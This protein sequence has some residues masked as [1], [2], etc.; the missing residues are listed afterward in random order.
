MIPAIYMDISNDGQSCNPTQ[1]QNMSIDSYVAYH[2]LLQSIFPYLLPF[3][4][5]FYPWCQIHLYVKRTNDKFHLE[6]GKNV[7]I[8]A[9]SYFLLHLPMALMT[10]ITFPIILQ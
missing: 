4:I 5:M 8:L 10:L 1:S 3:G 7:A 9:S 6:V 2:L